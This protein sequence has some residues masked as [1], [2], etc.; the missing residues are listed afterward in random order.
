[1]SVNSGEKPCS[2]CGHMVDIRSEFC[3]CCGYVFSVASRYKHIEKGDIMFEKER[4]LIEETK[5]KF[6]NSYDEPSLFRCIRNEKV[7]RSIYDEPS[8]YRRETSQPYRNMSDNNGVVFRRRFWRDLYF[9]LSPT[10]KHGMGAF[11]LKSFV[12]DVLHLHIPKSELER[13]G[14]LLDEE[15]YEDTWIPK[16][17]IRINRRLVVLLPGINYTEGMFFSEQG[18]HWDAD[19]LYLL[20][21]YGNVPECLQHKVKCTCLSFKH[22]VM[23]WLSCCIRKLNVNYDISR[24][25]LDNLSDMTQNLLSEDI[26]NSNS[27]SDTAMSDFI[28]DS[29]ENIEAALNIY[30]EVHDIAD[31]LKN[32]VLAAIRLELLKITRWRLS[33]F[34]DCAKIGKDGCLYVRSSIRSEWQKCYLC[35]GASPNFKFPNEVLF[36]LC[37]KLSFNIF[38][39]SCSRKILGEF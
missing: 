28:L 18:E 5:R 15:K 8:L 9:L 33:N 20:T 34:K 3:P 4:D 11:F 35:D 22:D 23:N 2:R 30:D 24:N 38:V 27:L 6:Y 26:I 25:F 1:M 13:V 12:Y 16:I 10:C 31:C 29:P 21:P 39:S 19:F 7:K 14:V 32:R 37:D 36:E 17:S